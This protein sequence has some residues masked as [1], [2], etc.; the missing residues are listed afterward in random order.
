MRINL[1]LLIALLFCGCNQNNANKTEAAPATSK[2]TT[3]AD[4]GEFKSYPSISLEEMQEL[5][6]KTTLVDYVFYELPM[7]LNLDN[8]GAIGQ[9]LRQISDQPAKIYAQCKAMGRVIFQSNGD[10]LKEADF[11]FGEPCFGFVFIE[12]TKPTKS[13]MMTKEGADFF[14]NILKQGQVQRP[15]Q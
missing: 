1:L 8:P 14:A 11:Y 4:L 7:S 15:N 5:V 13:N 2:S 9:A 12:G 10:I 6:S 3:P